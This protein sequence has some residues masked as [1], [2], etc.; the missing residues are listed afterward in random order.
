MAAEGKGMGG[1][2]GAGDDKGRPAKTEPRRRR[3][4]FLMLTQCNVC[5]L[6]PLLWIFL[7]F[8]KKPPPP[9]SRAKF[10]AQCQTSQPLS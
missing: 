5:F 10:R 6:E 8:D 9:A 7:T 1:A 4:E 2:S 3:S